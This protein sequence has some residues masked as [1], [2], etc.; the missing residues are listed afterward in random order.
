M[1]NVGDWTV[2]PKPTPQN[3]PG[4][5]DLAIADI[6]SAIDKSAIPE[7]EMPAILGVID[8]LQERREFGLKKYG[9]LLQVGNGRNAVRDALDE[10]LDLIVY[11]R[12]II[13]ER[14]TIQGMNLDNMYRN[15]IEFA[16]ALKYLLNRESESDSNSS[17]EAGSPDLAGGQHRAVQEV[18][19]Q[20]AN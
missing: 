2:Q 7:S 17:A 9:T 5:H 15:T 10:A 6:Y 3:T 12:L 16:I 18:P 11:M 4:M 8:E 1:S 14:G 13:T 20:T 19:S